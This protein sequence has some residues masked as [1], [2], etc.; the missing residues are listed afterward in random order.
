[1]SGTRIM[2][3][4]QNRIFTAF[5]DEL[6]RLGDELDPLKGI[7]SKSAHT[8]Q[9]IS[10]HLTYEFYL[11]CWLNFKLNGGKSLFS[12]ISSIGFFNKMYLAKNAGMPKPIFHALDLINKERN[13]LA[14]K[15]EKR[16]VVA[17]KI[18]EFVEKIDAISLGGIKVEMLKLL[19]AGG[20]V[21][22]KSEECGGRLLIAL[23][24]LLGHLRNF[25]FTSIYEQYSFPYEPKAKH[26]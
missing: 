22:I 16:E 7:N 19:E 26:D 25:V 17:E 9:I 1:M 5:N 13:D 21:T 24:G 15:V 8:L 6:Q 4:E 10:F 3:D 20:E 11:D 12:G 14:H 23:H 2:D 18:D